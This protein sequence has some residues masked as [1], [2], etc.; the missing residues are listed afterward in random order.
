MFPLLQKWETL[1]KHAR[2]VNVSGN[3]PPRFLER[4]DAHKNSS[5]KATAKIESNPE[6]MW[7][8]TMTI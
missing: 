7:N 4:D 2:A 8:I 5:R 1:E 6:D 3:I